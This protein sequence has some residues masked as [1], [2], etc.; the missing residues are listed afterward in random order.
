[1]TVCFSLLICFIAPFPF[2]DAWAFVKLPQ[3]QSMCVARVHAKTKTNDGLTNPADIALCMFCPLARRLM[4]TALVSFLM[5]P[6][7]SLTPFLSIPSLDG[8]R[9]RHRA[10]RTLTRR[11]CSPCCCLAPAPLPFWRTVL[12]PIAT[13]K[14]KLM[15][16]NV[17]I[18]LL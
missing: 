11:T 4:H 10:Q 1:M 13:V 16:W 12:Q 8:V 5:S 14:Y 9:C 2:W 17:S 3:K 18:T 6:S 15:A 7:K